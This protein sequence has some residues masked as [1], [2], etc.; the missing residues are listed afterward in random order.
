MG[1]KH[2]GA[3]APGWTR[4]LRGI[5]RKYIVSRGS[6]VNHRSFYPKESI[7]TGKIHSGLQI[8]WSGAKHKFTTF[9]NVQLV[10]CYSKALDKKLTFFTNVDNLHKMEELGGFDNWLL[11]LPRHLFGL[12]P[13][14][15]KYR[16]LIYCAKRSPWNADEVEA[17]AHVLA[18]WL[19]ANPSVVE[20]WRKEKQRIYKER[21]EIL[22]D[23]AMLFDHTGELPHLDPNV[24]VE[25]TTQEVDEED[26]Q[27]AEHVEANQ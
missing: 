16:T 23:E 4:A 7:I 22:G 24:N 14:A 17:Q 10:T 3:R 26:D 5:P 11:Q 6:L 2:W 15:R 18:D 21:L 12:S 25:Y 27:P 20:E 19:E 13:M 8:Q 1:L 9:P